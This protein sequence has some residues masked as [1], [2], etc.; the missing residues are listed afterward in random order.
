MYQVSSGDSV[1]AHLHN[2]DINLTEKYLEE[3]EEQKEKRNAETKAFIEKEE[4]R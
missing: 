2:W 3:Y 1:E 4:K